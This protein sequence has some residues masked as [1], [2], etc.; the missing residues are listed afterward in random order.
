[1]KKNIM[2]TMLPKLSIGSNQNLDILFYLLNY[3]L[4]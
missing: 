3:F 4:K 2:L 1:L